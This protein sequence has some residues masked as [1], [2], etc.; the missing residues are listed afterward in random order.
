MLAVNNLPGRCRVIVY[1][2]PVN[3]NVTALLV[4]SAF[5]TVT[6][7]SPGGSTIGGTS[8]PLLICFGTPMVMAVPSIEG[9]SRSLTE[10][11]LTTLPVGVKPCPLI[12]AWIG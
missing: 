2:L 7:Y 1:G 6:R 3:V 12:V 8:P 5:V 10:P 9:S 4:P 11:K